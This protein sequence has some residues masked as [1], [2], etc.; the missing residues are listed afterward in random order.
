MFDKHREH[1]AQEAAQEA[2]VRWQEQRDGYSR[3]VDLAENFHGV[4]AT[5][6]VLGP[7]EAVFYKVTG[8]ALVEPRRG[9]GTYQG[10]SSG[11]SI[12]VGSIGGHSVRYRVG[13]NKGH[14]VAGAPVATAIDTGTVH[15]TNRRVVFQGAN[16]TRECAYTK[17]LGFQHDA[18]EGTTVLSVSNRQKPTTLHYGPQLS[19]DF[20]F[21]LDLA[22][23]DFRG[24][25]DQLVASLQHDLALIDGRK[26]VSPAI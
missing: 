7:S 16:Q 21:R 20:E 8:A 9:A 19:A 1:K 12:P 10:H 4:S 18:T 5:D 11:F 25:V 22:L 2:T 24:T 14:Y 3:L 23:A 15:I 26:P 13:V 17:L 6:L